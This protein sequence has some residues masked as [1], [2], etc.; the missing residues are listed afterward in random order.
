MPLLRA[1]TRFRTNNDWTL[2]SHTEFERDE[3]LGLS[4]PLA[5]AR[6]VGPDGLR[7]RNVRR[8]VTCLVSKQWCVTTRT[9]GSRDD[10]S[11]SHCPRRLWPCRQN[12]SRT[13]DQGDRW[14]G[15]NYGGVD[16]Y[17]QGS[18]GLT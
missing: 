3:L 5:R 14:S 13:A 18:C 1:L 4:G 10:P 6:H 15:P 16:R 2:G 9:E 11:H 12:L 17:R 8:L 7:A